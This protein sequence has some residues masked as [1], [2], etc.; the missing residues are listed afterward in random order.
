MLPSLADWISAFRRMSGKVGD[1]E[2][3]HHAPGLVGAVSLE[4]PAKRLAHGAARAVAADDVAGA[5]GFNLSF[6]ARFGALKTDGDWMA[7]VRRGGVDLQPGETPVVVRLQPVRRVAHDF[8]IEVVH[9][10][11]VEDHMR[12]LGEA[13]LDI[14]DPAAAGDRLRP[15]RIRFPEGGFVDPVGFLF[16][17]VGKTEGLEHLH[18]AAGNA[19]G[20]AELKRTRFLVDDPGGDLR[21]SAKLRRQRQPGRSAADDQD[22]DL[23]WAGFRYW[24]GR[25]RL[26]SALRSPDLRSETRS[27][28]I[29]WDRVLHS[30]APNACPSGL[31]ARNATRCTGTII[32][33][34]VYLLSVY[35]QLSLVWRTE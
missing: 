14:L 30:P 16:N 10:R 19:V 18:G 21:K 1:G 31:K 3:V 34:S 22:V 4:A 35:C 32:I 26:S 29:A 23:P 27:G 6:P 5:H 2:H 11:L 24:R 25:R 9:P 20:L 13:V 15:R 33:Y 17:P 12:K 7:P 28:G 8:Q